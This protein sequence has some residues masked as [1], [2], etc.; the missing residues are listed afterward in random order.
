MSPLARLT[1]A[2]GC[3]AALGSLM[4]FGL[5][6][7]IAALGLPG[8]LAT[9]LVNLLG[10]L[11]IGFAATISG[12]GGRLTVSPARRQ[13]VTSGFCGGFTTFSAM[14]LDA[15]LMLAARRPAAAA[16]YLV[17]VVALSLAAAAAGHAAAVRL[18]RS[19]WPTGGDSG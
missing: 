7:G 9:A 5:A 8:F 15:A 6:A 17:L 12:P 19:R 16:L 18:N 14:S 2:V 11:V 1:L 4:R 3:G 13:L 10:S